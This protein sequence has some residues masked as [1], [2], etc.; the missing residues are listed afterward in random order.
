MDKFEQSEAW[1]ERARFPL[2]IEIFT[3]ISD[4]ESPSTNMLLPAAWNPKAVRNNWP[5]LKYSQESE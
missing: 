3:R 1:I 4:T 2:T 5:W